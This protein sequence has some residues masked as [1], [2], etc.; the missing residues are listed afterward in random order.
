MNF[1][2]G[3]SIFLIS[4]YYFLCFSFIFASNENQ[5][6]VF[7]NKRGEYGLLVGPQAR[8]KRIPN[9]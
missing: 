2:L 5:E 8:G 3:S 1:M 9:N 6:I 7:K 4:F